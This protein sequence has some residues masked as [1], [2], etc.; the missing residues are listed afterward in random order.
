MMTSTYFIGEQSYLPSISLVAEPETLWDENIGIYE[1]EFKQREIPVTIHYFTPETDYGFTANAGARLGGLNIWTKPQKPFTIYTRNRFGQDFIHYQLFENKQIANFSRIVFRNGGDDWEETLIRDPM[2]ESLAM[3]MMDCGYMAYTPSALFLNGAYWGI[4]NIR[5][6]LDPHYFF[7]NFNVDPDNIDQLE[8]TSTPSGTQMLVVEG[9]ANHYNAMINY[10]LSNDLNEPAVYAH[11]KELMNVDSFIDFLVMTLYSAN[12]SW[13][14]NREWWR[15]RSDM[16]QW[17]WLIVDIDRGFNIYNVY[18][19]LLDNLIDDYDLFQY[20]LSSQSFQDRFVQRAAAHFSNTFNTDKITAIVDSLSNGISL[21]MPRHID[22]WGDE[23]GVSSMNAWENDLDDIKQF[24]QNRN[25]VLH[26]QFISE[27][28]LDGMVQVTVAIEPP[29]AG[30]VS[31]NDVP[32]ILSDGEGTYFKNKPISILAQPLLG[33][34][35]IGWEGVSD[36]I[37]IDY[38][39]ISDTLFTAVFQLSEEIILPDV[40]T[41]NTL[42]TNEQPYAVVQNLI[43]SSGVALTVSEGVE[44]RMPEAGNIIVEGQF[45]INGSEEDPVQIIPQSSIGDNRWGALSFHNE[46]DT[47][48]I[49]HLKL[50]GASTGVDPMVHHGAIS[51]IHSHIILDHVEIENVEFPV[52]VEGGSIAINNSSITCDFICDYINVKGGNALIENCIFYGSDAQDTDAIDLDN[53]I[54]GII[55]SN[56]IY[57]FTGFNSD[58]IDIGENSEDILISSNLIYHTGDKGISVGQGSTVT[59]DRNLVVGCNNGI[60]VKDNSTAYI[61]NNTFFY[62]DTAVSCSEKNVGAGGGTAEIVNTILSSN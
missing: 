43:I 33:Y 18:N 25:A 44:I 45:I 41:E 15:P 62:N 23:G 51:S 35:F 5:E 22:R 55:R 60:A 52:Y 27:L 21:E 12:T 40:I 37:R 34:Q 4:Y 3:G 58:G 7:E 53:V 17:Q 8:Y 20:L 39:C 56:Q 47:S 50:T 42:L 32:V 31:I 26:S 57:D 46:T 24:A 30:Q 9:D 36:S 48:T 16:G 13:G 49:S 54:G 59:L 11:I 28:N 14:H 2:T 10:I 19:N 38:N 6:K 29:G 61:I 1:N